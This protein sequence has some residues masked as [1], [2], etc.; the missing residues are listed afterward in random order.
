MTIDLDAAI[1]AV[2]AGLSDR[3]A[4]KLSERLAPKLAPLLAAS[5]DNGGLLRGAEQIA[6]HLRCPKSRVYALSSAKRIPARHD[7]SALIAYKAELDSWLAS[8]G[9][10]RP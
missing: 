10:K 9:G 6:Q 5:S 7:G 8:G 3:Q 1:D 4:E 2:I